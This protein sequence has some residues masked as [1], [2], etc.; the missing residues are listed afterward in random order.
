MTIEFRCPGCNQLLRTGNETAGNR[1]KCP[2]CSTVVVVPAPAEPP[3]T[4]VPTPEPN[5]QETSFQTFQQPPIAGG[6][7]PQQAPYGNV[8]PPFPQ[9][10][11]P[12]GSF[13]PSQQPSVQQPYGGQVLRPRIPSYMAQ[14][15]LCTLF[16]CLP[17][18][19]VAIVYAAQVNRH[20]AAGN[21]AQ[22]QEA[23]DKAKMWC[24]LSF[25]IGLGVTVLYFFFVIRG[26]AAGL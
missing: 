7:G 24:W 17:F 16:C 5:P 11:P 20:L 18:G 9:G 14:A 10:M 23:S 13:T 3:L 21:Y 2:K 26:A 15:I 22:A 12:G 1:A 6:H 8:P 4:A 25:G 19:I